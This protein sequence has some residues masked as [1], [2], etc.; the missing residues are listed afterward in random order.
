M[1]ADQGVTWA[2]LLPE[3]APVNTQ[4]TERPTG[5]TGELRKNTRKD[6]GDSGMWCISYCQ[7]TLSTLASHVMG[8]LA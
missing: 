6:T 1:K 4:H 3:T 7:Q 5:N 2:G 8:V